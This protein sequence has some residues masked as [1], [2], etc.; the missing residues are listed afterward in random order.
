MIDNYDFANKIANGVFDDVYSHIAGVVLHNRNLNLAEDQRHYLV[1]ILADKIE[2]LL[3]DMPEFSPV[4]ID[5]DDNYDDTEDGY[6]MES[7]MWY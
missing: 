3:N 5:D 6:D 4:N 1:C 2:D 7:E